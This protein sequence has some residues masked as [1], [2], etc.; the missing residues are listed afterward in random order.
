MDKTHQDIIKETVL[1][2]LQKM[3]FEAA[4]DVTMEKGAGNDSEDVYA[5]MARVEQHQ[6]L[7]IGQY[8]VNLA[9]IQHLVR[10]MLRKK[11]Q[12]RLTIIV[13][14]NAYF[15]EKRVLLEQEA[16]KAAKEVLLSG[17][18]ITLRSMLPYERKIVHSFLAQNKDVMTE[19]IGKGDD[20]KVIVRPKD[21]ATPSL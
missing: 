19:S 1:D 4:V 3:G 16:E 14:I 9:A 6:N 17:A 5:C 15:A 8:G 18:A 20:R 10:V 21:T 7:L 12:E 11:I 2:L 13:D